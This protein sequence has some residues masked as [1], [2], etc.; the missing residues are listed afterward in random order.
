MIIAGFFQLS[1][2]MQVVCAGALRGLQDVKVPS[3]LI[4]VAYW[5]IALPLGYWFAFPLGYGANGIWIG[6]LIGLTVTATLMI[7]RFNSL[8]KKV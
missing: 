7:V 4:F 3:L 6:L 2:G 5:I 1:D 8:S